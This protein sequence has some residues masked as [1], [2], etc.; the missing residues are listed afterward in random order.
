MRSLSE[1]VDLI[2]EHFPNLVVTQVRVLPH[3]G[4]GGESDAL[5]IND[6]YIFLVPRWPEAAR[7]LAVDI[8]LLPKLAPRVA[9]PIPSFQYVSYDQAAGMPL[10]VGYLA[11]PGQPLIPTL[12]QA[13]APDEPTMERMASQLGAFL[14]GL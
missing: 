13:I 5:L 6:G 11:I 14:S 2:H 12:F 9:L 1:C 10:F 8:C 3:I 7:A 4:W